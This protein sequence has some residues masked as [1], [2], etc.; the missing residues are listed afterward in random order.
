MTENESNPSFII[1]V[2]GERNKFAVGL[3]RR[4]A[5][6]EWDGNSVSAKVLYDALVV[7]KE[8][9]FQNNRFN[10]GKADSAGRLYSGTM[11]RVKDGKILY[12]VTD[13]TL[14]RYTNGDEVKPLV[15]KIGISNGLA[16]DEKKRKFYYI[17][18]CGSNV[19]EYDWDPKTGDISKWN[20]NIMDERKSSK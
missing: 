14:Y 13:G 1:P 2:E 19:R 17:D 10:D 9:K 6:V 18:S 16:F 12:D 5:I 8:D 3:K 7:E 20:G 15:E 4:I 11:R